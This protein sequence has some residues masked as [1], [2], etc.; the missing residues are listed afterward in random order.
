MIGLAGSDQQAIFRQS[1]AEYGKW[2]EKAWIQ[3]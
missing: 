3:L 1:Q 2:L